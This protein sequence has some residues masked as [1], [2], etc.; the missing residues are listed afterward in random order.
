V[1][2][3][4]KL[5][6]YNSIFTE[7]NRMPSVQLGVDLTGLQLQRTGTGTWSVRLSNPTKS[8]AFFSRVRLLEESRSIKSYYSDNDISLLPH[9]SKT[10]SVR[11]EAGDPGSVP[12]TLHVEIAGWNSPARTVEL[13]VTR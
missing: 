2:V 7:M 11:V 1:S 9:E 13:P 5:D 3:T 10:I 8:L 6:D 12:T 4:G